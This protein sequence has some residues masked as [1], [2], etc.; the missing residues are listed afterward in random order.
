MVMLE[1]GWSSHKYTTKSLHVVM[2][3]TAGQVYLRYVFALLHFERLGASL[4]FP[5]FHMPVFTVALLDGTSWS[6]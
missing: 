5:C 6:V 1:K 4:T 2:H 3:M